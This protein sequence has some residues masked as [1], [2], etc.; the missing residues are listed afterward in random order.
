LLLDFCPREPEFAAL[1][2][3]AKRL[4]GVVNR[5][6]DQIMYFHYQICKCIFASDGLGFWIVPQGSSLK[7]PRIRAG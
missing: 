4:Q 7:F 2:A 1:R 3:V 5:F 6:A